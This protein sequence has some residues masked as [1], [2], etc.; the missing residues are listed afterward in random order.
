MFESWLHAEAT[1]TLRRAAMSGG[2]TPHPSWFF[3]S[4]GLVSDMAVKR[5]SFTAGRGDSWSSKRWTAHYCPSSP[6]EALTLS[7]TWPTHTV[8]MGLRTKQHSGVHLYFHHSQRWLFIIYRFDLP[9][10]QFA[11]CSHSYICYL[12]KKKTSQEAA[13]APPVGKFVVFFFYICEMTNKI[14][15]NT[16]DRR[17]SEPLNCWI[18]V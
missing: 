2:P 4:G 3:P 7:S 15:W 1:L 9:P 6:E 14:K 12:K 13:C 16:A 17:V 11:L 18:A 5:W 8:L 10:V